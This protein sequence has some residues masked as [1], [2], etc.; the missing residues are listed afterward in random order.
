MTL[1]TSLFA[2]LFGDPDKDTDTGQRVADWTARLSRELALR[3]PWIRKRRGYYD[4]THDLAYATRLWRETFGPEFGVVTDNWCQLVIDAAVE[5]MTVQG[6]R[7]GAG[8]GA[9]DTAWGIWQDNLLDL[10]A[11]I[12]HTDALVTGCSYLLVWPDDETNE[13][14]ITV[15]DP[16]QTIVQLDPANRRR[17][18]AALKRWRELDDT[19]HA[20]LWTP[21]T[22]WTLEGG[23]DLTATWEPVAADPNPLGVVP[24]I[25]LL[26]N[27]NLYGRGRSDLEP[28]LPLQ[29]AVNKLM[30]DM[31]V[32]SEF[33]AYPQRV[34]LGA[35]LPADPETGQPT[36][37]K[38]GINRW[39]AFDGA[40]DEGGT[41]IAPRIQELS[42]ADLKNY[43]GS[44][45][46]LVQHIAALSKTPPQYLLGQMVNISGD[47]LRAAESGLVSRV[48]RRIRG[49]G[50]AWEEAMRLAFKLRGDDTHANQTGAETIW[51]DPETISE[52]ARVDA[53]LKMAQLGVP[54]E[55]LWEKWGATPQ[56]IEQWRRMRDQQAVAEGLTLGRTPSG[57]APE[58]LP[59]ASAPAVGAAGA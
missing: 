24:V 32:A 37:I 57:A 1:I 20:V 47:A 51:A 30:A 25:P 31:L 22:V 48:R 16:L 17:R 54:T 41:P 28:V 10:Q 44:I 23:S 11:D 33:A 36:P 43:I 59:P 35:E 52:A 2:G 29:D 3:E 55:A 45:E 9:D 49:A 7:L 15:E 50:E 14:R 53:L 34:L 39:M 4:G 56:Q 13:P 12:A 19:W 42:A 46:Q 18:R 26:N 6:F 38:G 40:L 5:R 8:A 27:P 21:D 58:P